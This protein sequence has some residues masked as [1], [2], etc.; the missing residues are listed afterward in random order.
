MKVIFF[1]I[2]LISLTFQQPKES[3][4]IDCKLIK[5]TK[6]YKWVQCPKENSDDII[7]EFFEGYW[8]KEWNDSTRV[9]DIVKVNILNE[10]EWAPFLSCKAR[11]EEAENNY[12]KNYKLERK[13]P[14]NFYIPKDC[15]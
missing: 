8:P 11:I 1:I 13:L 9:G 6:D 5:T 12:K 3:K 2:I 15:Q 14:N 7:M 4:I 10:G